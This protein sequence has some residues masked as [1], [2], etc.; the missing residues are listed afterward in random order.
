M[1][2]DYKEL[3]NTN[4]DFPQAMTEMRSAY[5]RIHKIAG[6]LAIASP[7]VAAVPD[8]S[9][10]LLARLERSR[11]MLT[12][13]QAGTHPNLSHDTSSLIVTDALPEIDMLSPAELLALDSL[14]QAVL[15][16]DPKEGYRVMAE[17]I[18]AMLPGL[19]EADDATAERSVSVLKH[20]IPEDELNHLRKNPDSLG[21]DDVSRFIEK[22][23]ETY[24][25]FLFKRIEMSANVATTPSFI[26][27]DMLHS[28]QRARN[29]HYNQSPLGLTS[30][31]FT[32]TARNIQR[33]KY[34]SMSPFFSKDEVNPQNAT[35]ESI[36]AATDD[37][38]AAF[39]DDMPKDF[40]KFFTTD[41]HTQPVGKKPS[42]APFTRLK[43]MMGELKSTVRQ[44]LRDGLSR[45]SKTQPDTA[46]GAAMVRGAASTLG[47]AKIPSVSSF[48]GA[49]K[50]RAPSLSSSVL[51][52]I[53]AVRH[54]LSSYMKNRTQDVKTGFSLKTSRFKDALSSVKKR[55]SNFAHATVL[56]G[57]LHLSQVD[58]KARKLAKFTGMK[59]NESLDKIAVAKTRTMDTLGGHFDTA[60]TVAYGHAETT[61]RIA[62]NTT[63]KL[64]PYA[65]GALTACVALTALHG[66]DIGFNDAVYHT[67]HLAGQHVGPQA[68]VQLNAINPPSFSVHT[69][70]STPS[71]TAPEFNVGPMPDITSHVS[72]G[73]VSHPIGHAL[74]GQE[75]NV[76]GL[77][78]LSPDDTRQI[79]AVE[80]AVEAHQPDVASQPHY[81]FGDDMVTSSKDIVH[82]ISDGLSHEFHSIIGDGTSIE[83]AITP[84]TPSLSHP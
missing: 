63:K 58:Y 11:M 34:K 16:P 48:Y 69:G 30:P 55:V 37:I 9:K 67:A 31:V 82:K 65:V 78:S 56:S 13:I 47:R 40:G 46:L 66:G 21:P 6:D 41:A 15:S 33:E 17:T 5:A 43:S 80:K 83:H 76:D 36:Q 32:G 73:P 1:S 22:A 84:T 72:H 70:M 14:H 7:D 79:H 3:A 38:T 18:N 51:S 45:V 39:M 25:E 75:T 62:K 2:I 61:S 81:N 77:T 57:R 44:G 35:R 54:G 24:Q 10:V 42:I 29:P 71:L 50:G 19:F 4:R 23:K 74:T 12:L 59:A 49:L 20:F 53:N 64:F 68:S 27:E 26:I 52:N 60:K 28:Y 8:E